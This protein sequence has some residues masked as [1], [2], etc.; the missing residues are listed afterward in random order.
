MTIRCRLHDGRWS[1]ARRGELAKPL[2]VGYVETEAGA[3]A[4]HPDRQVQDRLGYIFGLFAELRVA[5]RVVARL[6]REK[7]QIPAQARGGPGGCNRATAMGFPGICV[8]FCVRREK[9]RIFSGCKSRPATQSL[10]P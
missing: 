3:V 10:Q 5:R 6:R 7:L 4:K 2:P 9:A 8:V 1:K